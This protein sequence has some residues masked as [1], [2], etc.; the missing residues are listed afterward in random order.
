MSNLVTIF[1]FSNV[2]SI[3]VTLVFTGRKLTLISDKL[4]VA[5]TAAT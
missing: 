1:G 3:N 4:P 5:E 2:K